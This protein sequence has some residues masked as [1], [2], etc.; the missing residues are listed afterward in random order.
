[1]SP[2][3]DVEWGETRRRLNIVVVGELGTGQPLSPIRLS[4][5]DEHSEILLYFLIHS[6]SLSVSLR[7]ISG[8]EVAG[9]SDES[10]QIL[11]L[12][13]N[14]FFCSQS[15]TSFTCLTCSSGVS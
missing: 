8:R 12:K 15:I 6:F 3:I 13:K 1:V 14:L 5:V 9:D 4:V 11:Q 10:T 7:M 2:I